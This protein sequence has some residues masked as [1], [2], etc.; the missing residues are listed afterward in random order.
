MKA[1]SGIVEQK[2]KPVDYKP[3][4]NTSY[5]PKT[6]SKNTGFK[7]LKDVRPEDIPED[8]PGLTRPNARAR[9]QTAKPKSMNLLERN[10]FIDSKLKA[11][12]DVGKSLD[13]DIINFKARNIA[14]SNTDN[15]KGIDTTKELILKKSN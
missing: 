7:Y 12:E 6:K 15:N 3:R 14:K 13:D 4:P 9:P 1:L 5:V 10:I 2:K 11:L 8:M